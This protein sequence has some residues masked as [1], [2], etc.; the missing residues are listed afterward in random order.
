MHPSTLS[1]IIEI[2]EGIE[3]LQLGDGIGITPMEE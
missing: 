2:E 3:N 1:T